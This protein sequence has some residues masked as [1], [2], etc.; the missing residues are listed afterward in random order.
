MGYTEIAVPPAEDDPVARQ[1]DTLV[2]P[3]HRGHRLGLWL[4][5]ANLEQMVGAHP[6]VRRST[7]GT[8]TRTGT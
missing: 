2:T 3:E 8:P 1:D 7:R 4:K 5:L 6:E